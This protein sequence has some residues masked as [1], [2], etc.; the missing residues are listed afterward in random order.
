MFFSGNNFA[1]RVF[2]ATF[3]VDF[4]LSLSL[5]ISNKYL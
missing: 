3:A 5:A 2:F 4:R 1:S